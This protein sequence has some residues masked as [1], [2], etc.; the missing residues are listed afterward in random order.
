[1]KAQVYHRYGPPAVVRMEKVAQPIPAPGEVLIRV[2]AATVNT[3]DWRLRA[4]A[5]PGGL[6]L[7]GRLM[8]GLFQPKNRVLGS[9]VAGEV[10]A[11]GEGVSGFVLGQRV[12]GF[13]GHGAHAEY[14]LA[15]ADGAIAP[16]P[17]ALSFQKAAA[18]P[19]G[20]LS[21][22]VFLRDF[23]ALKPGQKVLVVGASGNVGVY[24]VQIAKA[25]GA[26]VTGVASSDNLEL[27]RSLGAD[28]VVDYTQQ[29]VTQQA[30]R[31]DLVFE[32][33]GAMS[34][35]QAR[36]VLT[37][38]GTFLPL[39]FGLGDVPTALVPRWLR[40]QRFVLNVNP[41]RREDLETLVQM[42]KKGDLRPVID[43]V[44]P[45][46]DIRAA[47]TRVEGRRRKGSIV[48]DVA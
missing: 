27:V 40:P 41:D 10:E 1:M 4:S 28:H 7:P 23:G 8:T 3:A 12:F 19:F 5:F 33:V 15:K 13:V 22:L 36:R 20:G 35:S 25:L 6:W 14:V 31:F 37:P 29:D 38:D 21:A 34:F 42:T 39:N 24:G 48:L 45:F 32:T 43:T 26:E 9:E 18:L 47:Y 11:L 17:D 44:F 30:E 2:R 16:I 46:E